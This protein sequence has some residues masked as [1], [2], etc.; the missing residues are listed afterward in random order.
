[1]V[2]CGNS[3]AELTHRV[4]GGRASVQNL[5]N[6]LRDGRTGSPIPGQFSNLLL[7]GD[8]AGKEQPEKTFWQ[9]LGATRC[10]GKEL[11]DFGDSLAAEADALIWK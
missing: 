6:E 1:M 9:G 8:L 10:A 3:Q 5:L 7:G 2:E 11:L 4:E